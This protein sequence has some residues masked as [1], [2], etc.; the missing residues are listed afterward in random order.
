MPRITREVVAYDLG[1]ETRASV[2][3]RVDIELHMVGTKW[4]QVGQTE[5]EKADRRAQSSSILRVV[6]A[7][8][9]LL[10]MD[11]RPCH[12]DQAFEEAMILVMTL[13]PQVFQDVVGLVITALIKTSKVALIAWIER[14]VRVRAKLFEEG[15]NAIDFFH[16][17]V[18][19]E[20]RQAHT[21]RH[22]FRRSPDPAS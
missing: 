10:Q 6:R 2:A 17:R 3:E 9:L 13:Q 18:C 14:E 5:M 7:E 22:F 4:L 15:V 21:G 11:E 12:L 8:E 16:G 19:R 1:R 20:H